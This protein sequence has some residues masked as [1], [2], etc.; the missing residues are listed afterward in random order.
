MIAQIQKPIDEI[1]EMLDGREKLVLYGCGGCATVFHT[2]GEPEV[3]EMADALS[4]HGKS[5]LAAIAPPFGEFTCY[6]P[7]SKERLSKYRQEIEACDA[8]LMMSCGDGFQVV[9]ES[10]LENEFGLV[11]PIYPANDAI[12]HMG[13]GPSAFREKC[14]QCGE[15]LLGQFAGICPMTQCAKGLL[16]GPCGGASNGKCEADPTRDCAWELI[17]NRLKQLGELDKWKEA[18][19]VIK[20]YSKMARP[21]KIEVAPLVL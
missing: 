17:Y 13:G 12:G 16:N 2:G 11:K 10:V 1:L 8:I 18:E 9:R 6:A 3:K 4:K 15:C 20:D 21:R 19:P 14:I 7:W 5:I